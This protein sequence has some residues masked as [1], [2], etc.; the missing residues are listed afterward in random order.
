MLTL[1]LVLC[2][3]L[4]ASLVLQAIPTLGFARVLRR[5]GRTPLTDAQCPKAAVILCLRGEDP[6]LGRCLESLFQQSYPD[7]TIFVV[8][9]SKLDPAYETVCESI[10]THGPDN[11]VVD[12][13]TNRLDTCSLKG[14]SIVQAMSRIDE[15]YQIVAMIDSDVIPHPTWLRELAAPLIDDAVGV[16]SGTRWYMPSRPTWGS[17]VRYYWNAA[18]NVQMYWN[19]ITWGGSVA[20]RGEIARHPEMIRSWK[21]AVSTDT[22]ILRVV[23]LFQKRAEFVPSLMMINRETCRLSSFYTWVQRQMVVVRLYHKGWVPIVTHGMLVVA[24]LAACFGVVFTALGYGETR[25]AGI[26][27]GAMMGY[28]VGFVALFHA[29]EEQVRAVVVARGEPVETPTF[30]SVVVAF[31]SVFITP[32]VYAAVLI[33]A[34]FIRHVDWRGIGYELNGPHDVRLVSYRPYVKADRPRDVT[35]SI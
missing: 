5:G 34:C 30:E 31:L 32:W 1:A 16:S 15:S 28:W 25:T 12:V 8:V 7:F 19:E 17:F 21:T 24:L 4:A 9:D 33:K 22:V 35:A 23:H 20:L 13:L 11:V 6:F 29:L 26:L 18:A 10:A 27:F 2:A 3:A 14:S